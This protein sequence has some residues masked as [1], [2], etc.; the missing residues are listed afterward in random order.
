MLVDA[1]EADESNYKKYMTQG[2]VA[3][4]NLTEFINNWKS[5]ELQPTLKTES[6][7]EDEDPNAPIKT[8]VGRTFEEHVLDKEKDVMVSFE[9]PWCSHCMQFEETYNTI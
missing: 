5:G 3:E 2:I 4:D 6:P 9:A 7:P 8:L 1:R